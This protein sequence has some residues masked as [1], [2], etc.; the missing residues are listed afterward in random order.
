MSTIALSERHLG[1]GDATRTLNIC[2]LFIDDRADLHLKALS[3]ALRELGVR[4]P[5]AVSDFLALNRTRLA[6]RV[7][8][9]V[10]NKLLTGHKIARPSETTKRRMRSISVT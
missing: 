4:D 3:W 10:E 6:T 8:R 5:K 9:E 2:E 1:R 7:I